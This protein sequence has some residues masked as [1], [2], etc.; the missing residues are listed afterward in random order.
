LGN[1]SLRSGSVIVL[2]ASL[3]LFSGC[4]LS[5]LF[6]AVA[7]EYQLL[8]GAVPVEEA[9]K[10]P[11]LSQ[12]QRAHLALVERIKEFGVTEL[13][14]K[15]TVSYQTVNLEP[16]QPTIYVVSACPKDRLR[17]VTW[18]FPVVGDMPYLGFFDLESARLEKQKLVEKDLD[19][20]I[21]MADAYSTLG[22]FKDPLTR[23]LIGAST[24]DFVET[25]LHE[26]THTTFYVKG[27]G[28]FNEGLAM[29]VAKEGALLFMEK[30]FGPSDPLSEE[31]RKS[32]HD[33]RLFS[34]FLASL[35]DELNHVYQS[36]L[37][38]QEKLAEREKVFASSLGRFKLLKSQFQTERFAP[39]EHAPMN[40]A[41]LISVMIYHRPYL[42]FEQALQ[43]R[44]NSIKD[45]LQWLKNMAQE[46][47]N[48]LVMMK[49]RLGKPEISCPSGS[50]L[51][52]K[53][54]SPLFDVRA[55]HHPHQERT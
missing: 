3:L 46:D 30:T 2:A 50:G 10:N 4:G 38:Y 33:E 37:S 8:N 1:R 14:L 17:P 49:E 9:M 26:M 51:L 32:I 48:M 42:L 54:A 52:W 22:W 15:K 36:P 13:G 24:L 20:F 55:F 5:Y 43:R 45:M 7:G 23:N 25:I 18:W 29:L 19:A 21:G 12:S 6:Q 28:E 31:A 35:V 40:N 11:S 47:G 34:S 27:Q 44:G 53:P 16:H 39:F 41:F